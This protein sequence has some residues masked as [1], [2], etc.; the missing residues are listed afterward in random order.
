MGIK[1]GI[2]QARE[3]QKQFSKQAKAVINNTLKGIK[4]ITK[5][6]YE[7]I[8]SKAAGVKFNSI[9]S[10]DNFVDYANKV[11]QSADYAVKFE[12]GVK[13]MRTLLV[14]ENAYFRAF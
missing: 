14:N 7:S 11:I 10:L 9:A 1:E 4:G 13:Q 8:A 6:Q 5:Q 2:N 3:R 12:N